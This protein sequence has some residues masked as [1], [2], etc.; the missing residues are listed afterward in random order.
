MRWSS[1]TSRLLVGLGVTLAAVA[2]FSRYALVQIDGLRTLQA[3]TVDRNHRDSLQLIRIQNDLHELALSMRDMHEGTEPY[4]LEAYYTEFRR[5]R[6]DLEDALKREAGLRPRT[7]SEAQQENLTQSATAFWEDTERMFEAARAGNER[8]ARQMIRAQLLNRQAGLSNLVSRLLV[9]NSDA[10]QRAA[11]EIES[12]YSRV[13]RD[14]YVFLAAV[15]ITISVTSLYLIRSNR[16]VFI[17]IEALSRQRQTLARKLIGVQEEIFRSVSREL[18]DEFGQILTAVGAILAR[19]E[20]KGLPE[21]SSLREDLHDVRIT[22]QQ[23][24]VKLRSLSQTLHPN[25][26]DDFGLEKTLEWYVG[27]FQ[28][29]TGVVIR[30]ERQGDSPIIPDETAI[31]IYRILQETLNNV[32]RH[33]GVQEADVKVKFSPRGLEMAVEDRGVGMAEPADNDEERRGLGMVAMRE[34]AELVGGRLRFE[35]PSAGG[36]RVV[37]EVP[38]RSVAVS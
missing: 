36:T 5:L 38:L 9:E 23:T 29:Q 31:H 7:R 13:E 35:R 24:L 14:I 12:I 3:D 33:A 8:E 4:P 26:L 25:V 22:A 15:L 17:R 6:G 27:Q 37:L 18:H 30:Y 34:R 10:E 1:P 21:N 19:A 20:K 32:A 2:V 28:K 11:Q 16:Q